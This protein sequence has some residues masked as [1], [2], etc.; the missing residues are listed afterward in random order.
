MLGHCP[1]TDQIDQA[2]FPERGV[3][4]ELVK[5]QKIVK[6]DLNASVLILVG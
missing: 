2:M 4:I 1:G 3:G 5:R 6:F